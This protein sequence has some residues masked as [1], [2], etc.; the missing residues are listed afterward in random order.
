[1]SR[2]ALLL[3]GEP[4]RGALPAHTAFP[5][6]NE[7]L[8]AHM[9]PRMPPACRRKT[10]LQTAAAAARLQIGCSTAS[11]ATFTRHEHFFSPLGLFVTDALL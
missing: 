10:G 1:M 11:P 9:V 7:A 6:K 2:S 4:R 5:M 3:V 8:R